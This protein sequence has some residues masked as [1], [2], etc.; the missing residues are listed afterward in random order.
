MPSMSYCMYENTA[1]ELAQCLDNLENNLDNP[2]FLRKMTV[3]ERDGIMDLVYL[4]KQFSKYESFLKRLEQQ[5]FGNS[6]TE[7][8]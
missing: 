6:E 3:Y 8:E 4:A 2:D 5:Y 1:G 7:E